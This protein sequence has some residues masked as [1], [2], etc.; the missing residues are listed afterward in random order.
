[1]RHSLK[2]IQGMMETDPVDVKQQRICAQKRKC[3]II[4]I[5]III[6]II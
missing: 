3:D 6:Y 2:G 4:I 1:M 5:I